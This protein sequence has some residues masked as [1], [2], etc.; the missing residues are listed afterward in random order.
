LNNHNHIRKKYGVA[1]DKDDN[2]HNQAEPIK[3][4]LGSILAILHKVYQ[5]VR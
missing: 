1:G 4:Y 2:E 3:K 5:Q